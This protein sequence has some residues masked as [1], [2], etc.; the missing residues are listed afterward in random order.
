MYAP[1]GESSR[2][3]RRVDDM[4]G[5]QRDPISR[6]N[7]LRGINDRISRSEVICRESETIA[8]ETLDELAHQRET[9]SRT[10]ERLATTNVE[11]SDTNKVLKSIHFRLAANKFLLGFIILLELLII[12]CQLYLKFF[13]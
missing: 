11:L 13:K 6:T 12:G 3:N 5:P 4:R 8:T 9:L 1:I 2:Q 7:V 10:R